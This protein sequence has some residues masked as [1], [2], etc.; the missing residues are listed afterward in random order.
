MKGIIYRAT[1]SYNGK[2]YIGQ[3]ITS[4]N[5][6]RSEH[7]RDAVSDSVNHF[8]FALMQYGKDAFEWDILDEFSGS[9]EDVIHALNVAEEYHI[10]KHKS[11]I[12]EFG[13]NATKGGYS[14]DKF[15][16]SIR[17]RA[18]ACCGSRHV[19]Q[20]D[21]DGAFVREFDS[22]AAVARYFG[23]EKFKGKDI[24]GR[25]W[26][27]YQWRIKEN[28]FYPVQISPYSPHRKPTMHILAYQWDGCFYREYENYAQCVKDLGKRY[29][30]RD[31]FEDIVIRSHE[32]GKYILI[33]KMK[34]SFPERIRVEVVYP[35]DWG[36]KKKDSDVSVP[37]LQYSCDGK[38]L[39]EFPSIRDAHRRTGISIGSITRSCRKSL[40]FK[41]RHDT[42]CIWRLKRGDIR[43]CIETSPYAPKASVAD[44]KKL[45]HRVV[46]YD[47]NGIIIRVWDNMYQA[48]LQTGES[49]G[50]IRKQCMGIPTKKMTKS[51]W[52]YYKAV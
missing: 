6:R 11:L 12:D 51:I 50:L 13:Y 9:R 25:M 44:T 52:R 39:S 45:E 17:K 19:L 34:D 23:K 36:K 35:K 49:H 7:L 14:S 2:V 10:L 47:R 41:V 40:P 33:K 15:A 22:L 18:L 26:K 46:Q 32:I 3:T 8:H 27:G 42:K 31:S 21:L 20:Y 28:E 29:R 5:H 37:V 48:S 30:V 43:E 1:N 16:E 24:G 38:F 4:L